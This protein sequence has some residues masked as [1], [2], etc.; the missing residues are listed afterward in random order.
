MLHNYAVASRCADGFGTNKHSTLGGRKTR[1][2]VEESFKLLAGSSSVDSGEPE[3]RTRNDVA[4]SRETNDTGPSRSLTRSLT[5]SLLVQG[6]FQFHV[7]VYLL[8]RYTK[9][10]CS[11]S[12]FLQG[13]FIQFSN[14]TDHKKRQK[15]A[16]LRRL[17]GRVREKRS[18]SPFSEE[19]VGG[20]LDSSSLSVTC[21][22]HLCPSS[23][24]S[25]RQTDKEHDAAGPNRPG[26]RD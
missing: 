12:Q 5:R 25:N 2:E 6:L 4:A 18:I 8:D 19:A 3:T 17:E 11:S 20:S 16:E 10:S 24:S 15:M 21:G 23:L 13:S 14:R 26:Q 1:Q 7:I 22:N 9:N